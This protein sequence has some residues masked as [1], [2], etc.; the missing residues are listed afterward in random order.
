MRAA[1]RASLGNAQALFEQRLTA[2][3]APIEVS[4]DLFAVLEIIKH[5]DRVVT[6]VTNPS[7][8]Q[9]ARA[10]FI[11][12]LLSSKVGQLGVDQVADMAKM[13]WSVS[14]DFLLAILE[15]AVLAVLKDAEKSSDLQ[16][17]QD[18]LLSIIAL[19]TEQSDLR[20]FLRNDR[21]ALAE[22]EKVIAGL[23]EHKL[24]NHAYFLLVQALHS[25]IKQAGIVAFLRWVS[26]CAGKVRNSLIASVECALPPSP[27]QLARI[28]DILQRRFGKPVMV[29][30]A[31]NK[32]ILGGMRVLVGGTVLDGSLATKIEHVRQQVSS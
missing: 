14:E 31:L 28:T 18:E 25:D 8:E 26:E 24:S 2:M 4:R 20:Q 30:V 21:I 32:N 1:S 19:L 12:S 29:H 13:R 15:L 6:V 10:D 27:Q 16:K 3:Q 17:L 22:R 5:N 9:E 7:Y 11:T 23:L